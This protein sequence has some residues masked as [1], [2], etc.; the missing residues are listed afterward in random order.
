MNLR[1]NEV[2]A[3]LFPLKFEPRGFAR[4]LRPSEGD[5]N[6]IRPAPTKAEAG[7]QVDVAGLEMFHWPDVLFLG[8]NLQRNDGVAVVGNFTGVESLGGS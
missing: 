6:H 5:G 3:I 2:S 7:K 1:C 8:R 4:S